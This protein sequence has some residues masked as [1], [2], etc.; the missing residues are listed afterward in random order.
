M[1]RKGL[2]VEQDAILEIAERERTSFGNAIVHAR[3]RIAQSGLF[4]DEALIRVLDSHPRAQLRGLRQTH[5][6]S[7]SGRRLRENRRTR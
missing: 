7:G 4:E 3:H 1:L 6:A 5:R 2:K